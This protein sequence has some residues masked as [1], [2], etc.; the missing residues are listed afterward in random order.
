MHKLIFL[1]V[2]V[3]LRIILIK[4]RRSSSADVSEFC[5]LMQTNCK[6]VKLA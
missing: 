3:H 5:F 6:F 4:C 1:I 2:F